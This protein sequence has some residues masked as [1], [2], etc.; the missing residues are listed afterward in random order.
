M[1]YIYSVPVSPSFKDRGLSGY[2]FGPLKQD[3]DIY[4]VE[5]ETGHD[6]F[7]ISRRIAR[8]Y[9]VLCG[10]GYFSISGRRYD[11]E[12][13]MLVEVP[14]GVEYSYSG[15]M[16]LIIFST[17]RWFP[18]NDRFTRWNPDVVTDPI[19]LPKNRT[20]RARLIQLRLFGKSPI[21]VYLRFNQ[22]LWNSLP[23]RVTSSHPMSTYG[24]FLHRLARAHGNRAQAGSTYF[25]RNKP[26]LELIQRL[27]R[28]SLKTDVLR[29]A[30]LGCSTGAE[31][32]SIAWKLRSARP[33]LKLIL[34]AVDISSEAVNAGRQ[35]VYSLTPETNIFERM[36]DVEIEVMFER[37]GNTMTIKSWLREGI[38]WHVADA[39]GTAIQDL[40]GPQDIVIAS[41]FLCHMEDFMAER[42]LR[43]VAQLVTSG[44]YL[45]VSGIDLEVR[46]RVACDLGWTPIRELLEEIHEGDPCLRRLWPCHYGA[47]EPLK[48]SESDWICRYAA[49]FQLGAS[50]EEIGKLAVR[51][52]Q[53]G[54]LE[55]SDF[56]GICADQKSSTEILESE[57]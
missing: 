28:R 50:T 56:D 52:C 18:G 38:E 43:N 36:S 9:Y 41:N 35:G 23:Q 14:M 49:A 46:S 44:G 53:Y 47:L 51:S 37:N 34:H 15:K 16:R 11:V 25:L 22:E 30:V 48:K 21:G 4:Y 3:L 2:A 55:K 7:M 31:V 17:P 45:L 13:G 40:L 5:V 57:E 24:E 20:W 12:P 29:M 6:T 10:S 33:D 39:G 1:Q 42:C 54:E 32:Y 27:V 19:P 26:L 8:T